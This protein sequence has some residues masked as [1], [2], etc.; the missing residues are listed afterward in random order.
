VSYWGAGGSYDA[1]R[2]QG[3]L[4]L[5]LTATNYTWNWLDASS[6]ADNSRVGETGTT[7]VNPK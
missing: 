2:R 6:P 4:R 7:A 3:V 1:G 5:S